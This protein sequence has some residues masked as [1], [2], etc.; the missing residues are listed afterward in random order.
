MASSNISIL[1]FHNYFQRNVCLKWGCIT[2]VS[3]HTWFFT[4]LYY[5]VT[6]LWW[7]VCK[8]YCMNRNDFH[9]QNGPNEPLVIMSLPHNKG[10]WKIRCVQIPP[11]YTQFQTC[12]FSRIIVENSNGEVWRRHIWQIIFKLNIFWC[13]VINFISNLPD[14][15]VE[16]RRKIWTTL[17]I[18]PKTCYFC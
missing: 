12:V 18:G 14:F 9:P 11:L 5:K 15:S 1:I 7:E 16:G 10:K 6:R 3:K 13:W 8:A 4:F 17:Y 2:G